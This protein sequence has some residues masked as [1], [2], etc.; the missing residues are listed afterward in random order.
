MAHPSRRYPM[1]M[2]ALLLFLIGA[3]VLLSGF[4]RWAIAAPPK[5]VN[6]MLLIDN[7][8][9]LWEL[10]G[11]GSDPQLLRIQGA[12]LLIRLLGTDQDTLYRVGV[13]AFGSDAQLIA[14]LTPLT[15]EAAREALLKQIANPQPMGW[16]DINRALDLAY[17]QLFPN[18]AS[19]TASRTAIVLFTDGKPETAETRQDEAVR[20]AYARD[21]EA[22]IRRL[23][24][25][26]VYIYF[27]LLAN[28]ATDQDPELQQHYR[29]MWNRLAQDLDTVFFFET[30][31][32]LDLPVLYHDI[33]I[34][35]QGGRPQP[36]IV[37]TPVAGRMEKEVEIEE[38]LYRVIFVVYKADPNLAVEVVRPDGR[39]LTSD[40]PRVRHAGGPY[41]EVWSIVYP[42]PGTWRIRLSGQGRVIVWK[43]VIPG[44]TPALI[45][46][47][48]PT[49]TWTPTPSATPSPTPTATFTPTAIATPVAAVLPPAQ[50]EEQKPPSAP[51]RPWLRTGILLAGL[52]L[53]LFISRA[54]Y[55]KWVRGQEAPLEGTLRLVAAPS[56][57]H[58]SQHWIL[59]EY[60]KGRLTV[61]GVGCDIALSGDEMPGAV[62]LVGKWDE[63]G[64]V[65]VYVRPLR[66]DACRLNG[67][68][69]VEERP[70]WDGDEIGLGEYV[71]RYEN[72]RRRRPLV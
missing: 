49:P 14:P 19:S 12:Q 43:D 39:P 37:E 61:G 27:V 23:A 6:V 5:T 36:P 26:G 72:F 44:P 65:A 71:I 34:R 70:L 20:T 46:S 63:D 41:Q 45:P 17:R 55:L 54:V 60:H 13:I 33:A 15:D 64:E 7:S 47:P 24:G 59:G 62:E 48:T 56:G 66:P 35:M 4:A 2:P 52:L 9:S 30:R 11:V 31:D 8:G 51:L 21:L 40:D 42:T 57:W 16:T 3:A 38:N 58:P 50:R 28:K 22:R 18:G 67:V 68:P 69:L 29:P 32:A 1:F 53:V 10:G 25:Q